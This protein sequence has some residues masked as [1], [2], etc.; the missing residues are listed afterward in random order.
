M[1]GADVLQEAIGFQQ[2]DRTRFKGWP[3][4]MLREDSSGPSRRRGRILRYDRELPHPADETALNPKD[5]P[6]R[7]IFRGFYFLT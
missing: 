1:T 6:G 4:R 7:R 3:G 2:T 5:P